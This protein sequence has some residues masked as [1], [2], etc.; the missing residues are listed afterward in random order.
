MTAVVLGVYTCAASGGP[1]NPIAEATLEPGRGIVGDRYH[2]GAGT[3]SKKLKGRPDAEITLIESEEIDR[4]NAAQSLAVKTGDF[5]RNVVTIGIR[6]NDLVGVKFSVGAAVLEGIRLAEPCAHLAG[7]VSSKCCRLWSIAR[8][9][10]RASSRAAW[11]GRVIEST[12][13]LD[14]TSAST[15]IHVS[16]TSGGSWTCTPSTRPP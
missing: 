3:F 9:C 8:V 5:R 11:S 10:G 4:F 12:D 15:A 13:M 6:L 16:P 14:R 7:L 2:A 1:M